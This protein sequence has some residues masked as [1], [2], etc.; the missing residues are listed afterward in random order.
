MDLQAGISEDHS[1]YSDSCDFCD[2][3]AKLTMILMAIC[4]KV[5]TKNMISGHV[6]EQW[7]YT[8]NEAQLAIKEWR[9]FIL[10]NKVSNIDWNSYLSTDTP[11]HAVLIIDFAMNHLPEKPR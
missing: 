10:R 9:N 4:T 6:I 7:R 11:E 1:S 2:L 8:I 5:E 3:P